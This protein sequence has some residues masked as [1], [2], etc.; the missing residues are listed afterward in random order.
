MPKQI[1]GVNNGELDCIMFLIKFLTFSPFLLTKASLSPCVKSKEKCGLHLSFSPQYYSKGIIARTTRAILNQK[2]HLLSRRAGETRISLSNRHI[3]NMWVWL[4]T[5]STTRSLTPKERELT[6]GPVVPRGPGG[7]TG[8]MGPL[9]P[10]QSG[11]HAGR[12]MRHEPSDVMCL[13]VKNIQGILV[14]RESLCLLW[15]E[16]SR[17]HRR[18]RPVMGNTRG[19]GPIQLNSAHFGIIGHGILWHYTDL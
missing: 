2:P 3:I 7:P 12:T 19:V 16:R 1:R 18:R 15:V 4:W 6:L 5:C 10:W 13:C 8:P 11:Q 17:A 14:F 9:G